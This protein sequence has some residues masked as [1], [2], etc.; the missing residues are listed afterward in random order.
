M[1]ARASAETITQEK[2]HEAHES[3]NPYQERNQWRYG[4]DMRG[5]PG[6]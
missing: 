5:E 6:R 2:E 1:E 3:E 4:R